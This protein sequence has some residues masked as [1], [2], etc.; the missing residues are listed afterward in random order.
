MKIEKIEGDVVLVEGENGIWQ[1]VHRSLLP[2]GI[3]VGT[4]LISTENGYIIDE[5][6]ENRRY[7]SMK[8]NKS[9]VFTPR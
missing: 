6:A 7:A 8:Q 5:E 1:R 9:S 3:S 4:V 2:M